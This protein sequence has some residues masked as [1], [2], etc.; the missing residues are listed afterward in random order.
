MSIDVSDLRDFYA[1]PLGHAVRRLISGRIRTRWRRLGGGTLIGL[2]YATPYLGQFRGEADRIG[3][4]MPATQGALVWPAE[5]PK[6]SA[7]VEDEEL[8]LPDNSVDRLIVAHGLELTGRVRPYLRELWRVLTPEG[9]LIM[10]VPNRRGIWARTEMTP[11]GYGHPY[12]RSQLEKLLG[13]AL[14]SPVD[15]SQ[16]LYMP[17]FGRNAL[18][19]TAVAWERVGSRLTPGFAGVV[20]VEAAKELTAPVAKPKRLRP[21]A[22]LAP[23]HQ[24]RPAGSCRGDRSS[25]R[26]ND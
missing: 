22:V 12:S 21:L 9:R 16:A 24:T 10:I 25:R 13:D 15:W 7:L 26:T 8:P 5:G 6:L 19:R 17:P 11:F 3:A 23:I 2:G 18:L 4:L 14:F 1:T 20:I